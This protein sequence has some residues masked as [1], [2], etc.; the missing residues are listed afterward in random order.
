MNNNEKKQKL[1]NVI[2]RITSLDFD[3]L[4]DEE[5]NSYEYAKLLLTK[6]L[7]NLKH[8][9]GAA[10]IYPLILNE[11]ILSN[12]PNLVQFNC[13]AKD[14]NYKII[15]TTLKHIRVNS[16]TDEYVSIFPQLLIIQYHTFSVN[17][18]NID[19]SIRNENILTPK[20]G[21]SQHMTKLFTDHHRQ[22]CLEH[23]IQTGPADWD[24]D[25]FNLFCMIYHPS[26]IKSL[27][28]KD[29]PQLWQWYKDKYV[30]NKQTTKI[31]LPKLNLLCLYFNDDGD[32]VHNYELPKYITCLNLRGLGLA[33]MDLTGMDRCLEIVGIL[34]EIQAPKIKFLSVKVLSLGTLSNFLESEQFKRFY[35]KNDPFYL[36][37]ISIDEKQVTMDEF[38]TIC[39]QNKWTVNIRYNI[40]EANGFVGEP[41][42]VS[43]I[44]SQTC[45]L[46][47]CRYYV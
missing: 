2:S 33:D 29:S 25:I 5:K 24:S 7:Y 9:S 26:T 35:D 19:Q 4:N 37:V 38:K 1:L 28:V 30:K 18:D 15:P 27:H 16:L 3:Y 10:I 46:C 31:I 39:E 36:S 23:L 6:R 42:D 17:F 45:P 34:T 40:G 41:F 14:W 11:I 32:E 21:I 8:F 43:T 13:P 44:I 12:Y 20:M 22:S 47:R